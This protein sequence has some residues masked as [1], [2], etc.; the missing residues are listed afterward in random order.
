MVNFLVVVTCAA[1]ISCPIV[2][3]LSQEVQVANAAECRLKV[4][5]ILKL[6]NQPPERFSISCQPKK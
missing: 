2:G 1:G 3:V 5:E 6:Y 4:L